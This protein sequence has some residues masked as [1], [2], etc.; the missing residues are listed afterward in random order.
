MAKLDALTVT[1]RK[2]FDGDVSTARNMLFL[3]NTGGGRFG[4][5]AGNVRNTGEDGDADQHLFTTFYSAGSSI[6]RI[7]GT[8]KDTGNAGSN[9]MNGIVIGANHD[10]ANNFWDGDI[11][12]VIVFN[13][14]QTSNFTP[15]EGNINSYYSI[16]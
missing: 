9:T 5:F 7:D 13:S 2:I 14:S 16:F 15:L 1:N 4:Y 11:Q 8:Q 10:T 3:Q 6:L 12:E